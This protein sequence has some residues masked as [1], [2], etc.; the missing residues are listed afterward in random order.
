MPAGCRQKVI[1]ICND[2]L[3]GG[4]C[5]VSSDQKQTHLSMPWL[6]EISYNDY[7]PRSAV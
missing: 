1:S 4:Y 5:S 3:L 2:V 7:T 6:D